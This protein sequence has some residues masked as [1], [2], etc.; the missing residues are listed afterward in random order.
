[1]VIL[2]VHVD[3]LFEVFFD[4]FKNIKCFTT[5]RRTNIKI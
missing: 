4:F 3:E 2:T 1:M 5:R